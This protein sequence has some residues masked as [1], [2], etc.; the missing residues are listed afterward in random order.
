MSTPHTTAASIRQKTKGSRGFSLVELLVTF[1][2]LALASSLGLPAFINYLNRAKIEGTARQAAMM[3]T[4]SRLE[5]I[6]RGFQTVVQIDAEARE[7]VA[8]ADVDGEGVGTL[9]DG[10]FNPVAGQDF[11]ETDY[12]IARFP[13]PAGVMFRDPDGN[14][15]AAS[16]DGLTAGSALFDIDGTTA[17]TGAFRFG[18]P[19]GNFLETRLA[20]ASS[21]RVALRK[22]DPDLHEWREQGESGAW[23][24]N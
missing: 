2:V 16:I 12:E 21:V 6:T 10:V 5:A 20:S 9:P 24:W 17:A 19:R 1:S 8:F 11:R 7:I 4:A 18:D 15:G 22:W 13:L 3:M 14:E 23:A